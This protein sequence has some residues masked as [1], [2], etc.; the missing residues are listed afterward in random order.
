M[1][2]TCFLISDKARCFSQSDRTLYGNFIII[3]ITATKYT[4]TTTTQMLKLKRVPALG[5]VHLK[6]AISPA[7]SIHQR[8]RIN[9]SAPRDQFQRIQ[10]IAEQRR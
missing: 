4:V 7:N 10:I 3:I 8:P 1:S 5:T 2:S 9:I 6:N